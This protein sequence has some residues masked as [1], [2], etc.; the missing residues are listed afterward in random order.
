MTGKKQKTKTLISPILLCWLVAYIFMNA[1]VPPT[2]LAELETQHVECVDEREHL[3]ARNEFLTVEN[4]EMK[5]LLGGLE[6]EV[7]QLVQDS[8]EKNDA[9]SRITIEYKNLQD[10]YNRLREAQEDLKQGS[11]RE[12][13]RLLT[14]LQ[15]AQDDLQR[16]ENDLRALEVEL[17]EKRKNIE[18]MQQELRS[19][20]TRLVELERVLNSQ[21][22]IM[23]AL[24]QKVSSALLGFEGQG[25]TV[26]RKNGNV[27]VSLEEKLLFKTGSSEIGTEGQRALKQLAKVL[28]QNKDINIMIEGHTDDVPYISSGS[29]LDNW[30]LSVKRAT[31]VVR[32]LLDGTTIDPERL[33][34]AGRGEYM[35]VDPAKTPQARAKNRR[36]EIILT[37]DLDELYRLFSE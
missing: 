2:R 32:I 19:Q 15:A 36:T 3:K 24:R 30:D 10:R 34:A 26:T 6:T 8:I 25:L 16:R 23:N 1:C 33:T 31:A 5:A 20:K 37:P 22:S 18:E 13:K 12:T 28:E 27:Y 29:I 17:Q 7:E 35:P 14:E 4:T 11:A 9:F 21:D